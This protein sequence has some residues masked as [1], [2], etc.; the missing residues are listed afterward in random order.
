MPRRFAA[1]LVVSGASLMLLLA[2]AAAGQARAAGGEWASYG[3]DPGNTSYSPLSLIDASNIT[4]AKVTWTWSSPDD[5][6]QINGQTVNPGA[7]KGTPIMVDGVLFVRTSLSIVAAIDA[8]TGETLWVFDPVSYEA[9]RPTNLGYNTR[10][11]AHWADPSGGRVFVATGDAHLWALNAAT[12]ELIEGFGEGGRIDLTEGLR[13]PVPRSAY[14]M[15]S[16]PIVVEDVVI[17]GSSI[18]DV[19]AY[20][21]APPG[22]VRAFDVRTGE[23]RWIFHTVP[24]PGEFGNDTWEDGSW[25]YTGNTNVWTVMS[26]DEERGL[27]YLPIGTPTNDWYGGHRLGD[28]LFAESLVALE[29]ATGRRVWHFQTVHHGVWDYDP[30]AAPVLLDVTVD[31]RLIPAVAQITKQGFVFVFDRVTGE[32]VW[33]IVERP[34]PPSDVPGERLSPTQPFPTR[35]APFERQGVRED[36]LIDFTPELRAEALTRLEGLDYGDL[37]HPPSVR[38]TVNVPGWFGGANWY[39]GAADPETGMI[40]IPSRTSAM[41]VQL[42]EPDAE[43]SD[44]NYVRGGIQNVSGPRGLPL[45]QPPYLRVTAIDLKTGDHAWQVPLG[46][47]PRQ[48]LIDMGVADPGPLGGGGFTGPL[49]TETLL[50]VGHSGPRDGD[51]GAGDAL[52]A[53][54]KVTGQVVHAIPLPGSPT[55]TPMTYVANGQQYIAVAIT[56]GARAGIVSVGLE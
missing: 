30:P 54:D 42:V 35:P 50:F 15:M 37:F 4:G 9:G 39:G 31:G 36:E 27:V 2:T 29:A 46:D 21:T 20:M 17:V 48:Q 53:F 22:D 19:P 24:Q 43:R 38:G 45:F 32:P 34:V 56:D 5:S 14:T 44:F 51:A 7:F 25:E 1:P 18:Q 49:L 10:G 11:V 8:A 3:G 33:P 23:Q 55:G 6:I 47:G 26:A 52:L 13:R 40:Y 12:G 16:P 41:V 28:N